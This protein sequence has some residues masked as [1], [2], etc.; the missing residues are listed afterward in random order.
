MAHYMLPEIILF[1]EVDFGGQSI[2]TNLEGNL[3][4]LNDKVTSVIV[5]S[6]TWQFYRHANYQSDPGDNWQPLTPGK[7]HYLP[8]KGIPNDQITSFR[9]V[10]DGP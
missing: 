3:S 9:V 5:V 6:G 10:N 1:A 4:D 2:R 7:Y 8:E